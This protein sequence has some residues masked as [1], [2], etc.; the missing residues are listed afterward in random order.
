MFSNAIFVY[1]LIYVDDMLL[2]SKSKSRITELKQ[3]LSSEFEIK[4]L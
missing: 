1:L 4:D 3:V 2:I